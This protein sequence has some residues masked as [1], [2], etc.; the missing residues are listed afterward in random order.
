MLGEITTG[1]K[2]LKAAFE[3]AKGLN[4][5][6]VQG[7]VTWIKVELS[8]HI[9]EAQIA[10]AVASGAQSETATRVQE[11][12]RELSDI[13]DWSTEQRRYEMADTGLGSLASLRY[14]QSNVAALARR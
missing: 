4:D 1:L 10:L 2:S 6:A 13:K 12:E 14:C 11:L 3:I 8:A 9:L 7:D 5:E